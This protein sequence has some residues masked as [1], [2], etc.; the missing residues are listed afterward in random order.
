[1]AALLKTILDLLV[2]IVMI[3]VL[4][5]FGILFGIPSLLGFKKP[6]SR[7]VYRIARMWSRMIIRYIG[8]TVTVR[9]QENIPPTGGLCLV[10]NHA[11]IFDI[12]LLLALVNRPVG[13][14]AKRELAFIPFLNIW[15]FLLGG[16]FIDRK[17]IRRAVKTINAGIR[18]VKDGAAVIV[19]PEGTRSRGQG[20][21]PF[22]S[23]AFKLATQSGV[24]VVPIA[25]SGSYEVFEKTR[26]V[27]A[28]PVCVT[29][30]PPIITSDLSA[31]ERRKRL[32][33]TVH[34]IIAGALN[35]PPAV[36]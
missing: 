10:S 31:E 1:M 28:V 3:I 29:F 18:R 30:A 36:S 12:L 35:Q 5:P 4:C 22:R 21:L 2:T 32:A 15:I 19:F 13:F 11:S 23:G 27:C 26:R 7:I 24:P 20:L 9:G 17:N 14:I 8:C 16:F 25:I 34:D 33:D 6:L